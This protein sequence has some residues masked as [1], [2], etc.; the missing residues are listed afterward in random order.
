VFSRLRQLLNQGGAQLRSSA[1]GLL[2][3][4]ARLN[5]HSVYL[6]AT[7]PGRARGAIGVAEARALSALLRQA[8]QTGHPV[9]LLLDSAGARVDEGL[10]ALGAFRQLFREA[11]L[12]R[13]A[14]VPML[15]LLGRSCFGGASMLACVC[16]RR[17][18]GPDTRLGASGPA[19][20]EAHE[21]KQRFDA[22]DPARVSALFGA[23]ARRI[24]L[25]DDL[26]DVDSE[27]WPAVVSRWLATLDDSRPWD[28]RTAHA[29]LETRLLHRGPLPPDECAGSALRERVAV[30]LPPGYD[31]RFDGPVFSTAPG[32][33][34]G[35][36]VFAGCVSGSTVTAL[37]CWR[38]SDRLLALANGHPGS[39][40]VLVLDAQAHAP[41][42]AD[43][44][45]LL[46]EYLVHLSLVIGRLARSGH[47][48]ALWLPGAA[49]GAAYVAFASP[50]DR[51]SVLP[52]ARVSILPAAAQQRIIGEV[53]EQA[54]DVHAVLAAGV[55]DAVLDSRLA[56]YAREQILRPGNTT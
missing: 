44:T 13:L 32:P 43:E 5:G 40:I 52:S 21:G 45:V 35:K 27:D 9:I 12:T 56:A 23:S 14:G 41:T 48:V 42:V 51:V 3:A 19:V 33:A 16:M 20:I 15:A 1:P 47:R 34:R 6:A 24:V 36:A 26:F 25:M 53:L 50:A 11:L 8:R 39:P 29:A 4:E 7:D 18:F 28:L 22:S 37:D 31:A 38:L 46:S 49:S 2:G 30:L 55:A 17:A 54:I 10:P